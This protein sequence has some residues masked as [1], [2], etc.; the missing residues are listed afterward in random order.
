MNSSGVYVQNMAVAAFASI[1]AS[2]STGPLGQIALENR[3]HLME[4]ATEGQVLAFL[5]ELRQLPK[6]QSDPSMVCGES[7]ALLLPFTNWARAE[8]FKAADFG[9]AVVRAGETGPARSNP[10]GMMVY[11]HASSMRVNAGARN[12]VVVLGKDHGD[13]FWLTGLLLP[14]AW[15]KIEEEMKKMGA[16]EAA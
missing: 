6:T 7:D 2:I 10:P 16:S 12:V 1:P 5:R 4:Q 9:A 11:H 14:P 13:N 15:A 8:I 3:R